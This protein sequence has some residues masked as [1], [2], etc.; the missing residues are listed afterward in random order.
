MRIFGVY[1]GDTQSRVYFYPL[2]SFLANGKASESTSECKAGA[3]SWLQTL[4]VGP[5]PHSL[6]LTKLHELESAAGCRVLW[7]PE[8]YIKSC[9][10]EYDAIR[11]DADDG[12]CAK[13]HQ[14]LWCYVLHTSGS[15]GTPK[16]VCGTE[17]G[18]TLKALSLS[19]V[20]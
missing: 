18:Y 12:R 9:Y 14:R 2:R 20:Y 15:S 19:Q 7:L 5:A 3:P 16:G 13:Q 4:P 17:K 11:I 1:I 6:D 8:D 10:K